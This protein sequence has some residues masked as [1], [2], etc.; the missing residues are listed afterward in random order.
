MGLEGEGSGG[1]EGEGSGGGKGEGSWEWVPSCPPL[2]NGKSSFYQ[3]L[4]ALNN[5][6]RE[7][8][9]AIIY[10]WVYHM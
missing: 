2:L 7:K 1:G 3:Y 5:I 10:N 6:L 8:S 4:K 9:L